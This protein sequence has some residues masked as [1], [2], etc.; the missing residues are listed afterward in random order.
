M[1]ELGPDQE[2]ELYALLDEASEKG[3]YTEPF[4]YMQSES[5]DPMNGVFSYLEQGLEVASS[6]LEA[7]YGEP[8]DLLFQ[9]MEKRGGLL[10]LQKAGKVADDLSGKGLVNGERM[11]EI[12]QEIFELEQA[13]D[14]VMDQGKGI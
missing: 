8:E 5:I 10:R 7:R 9:R 3:D 2:N 1:K 4:C 14:N 6:A 11:G 13:Y 12:R